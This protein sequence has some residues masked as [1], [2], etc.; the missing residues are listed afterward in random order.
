MKSVCNVASRY[1]C[2]PE[3]FHLSIC[4]VFIKH[5]SDLFYDCLVIVPSCYFYVSCMCLVPWKIEQGIG[6]SESREVD[7]YEPP[8][9]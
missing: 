1:T 3:A 9:R 2:Q 6:S 7:G 4:F 5:E 8:Q